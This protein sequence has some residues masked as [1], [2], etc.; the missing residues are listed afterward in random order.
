MK[1][2]FIVLGKIDAGIF[3]APFPSGTFVIKK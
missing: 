3:Q 1:S 2:K